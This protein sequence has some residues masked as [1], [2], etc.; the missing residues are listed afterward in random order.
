[1]E[2]ERFDNVSS[3]ESW[4]LTSLIHE[5]NHSISEQVAA[6]LQQDWL[7]HKAKDCKNHWQA[8]Q[9]PPLYFLLNCHVC[10]AHWRAPRNKTCT[11]NIP[12]GC[13]T[14]AVDFSFTDS[15]IA[16]DSGEGC[17]NAWSNTH[18]HT[19]TQS[20]PKILR[21]FRPVPAAVPPR[22]AGRMM[23]GVKLTW[24]HSCVP[25]LTEVLKLWITSTAR[26]FN[27]WLSHIDDSLNGNQGLERPSF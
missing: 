23:W 15:Q 3:I 6:W 4:I 7:L 17:T 2:C 1:M 5:N 20:Q 8:A 26:V 24:G 19:H 27:V 14:F 22:Q 13:K 9:K 25:W 11:L 21:F 18:T 10:M 16:A 12:K